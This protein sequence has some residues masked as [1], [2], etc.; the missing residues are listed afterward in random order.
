[1]KLT[2]NALPTSDAFQS[3]VRQHLEA[4]EVVRIAAEQAAAGGGA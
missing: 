2:S 3:N 1:M 4:L